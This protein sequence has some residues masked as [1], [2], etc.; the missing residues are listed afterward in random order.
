M[1]LMTVPSIGVVPA[2]I[3]AGRMLCRANV[4]LVVW[5]G[6]AVRED[7]EAVRVEEGVEAAGFPEECVGLRDGR[8]FVRSAV[9][10]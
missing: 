2:P 6:R 5:F 10:L 8:A 9:C 3:K 1:T 7:L 4:T